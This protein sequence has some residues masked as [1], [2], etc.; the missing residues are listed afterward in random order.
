MY[1]LI[2]LSYISAVGSRSRLWQREPL[3]LRFSLRSWQGLLDRGKGNRAQIGSPP[4]M[5]HTSPVEAPCDTS[6]E[7]GLRQEITQ[8]TALFC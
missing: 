5:H 6:A 8:N 7:A 2:S 4:F 3:W 1:C